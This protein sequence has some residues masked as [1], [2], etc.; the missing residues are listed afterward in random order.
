MLKLLYGKK[1]LNMGKGHEYAFNILQTRIHA[2]GTFH[3]FNWI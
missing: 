1:N 2:L 3:I